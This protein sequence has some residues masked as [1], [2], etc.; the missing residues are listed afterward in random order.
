MSTALITNPNGGYRFLAGIDPYSSGAVAESG[1]EI[2]HVTLAELM[3]WREGLIAVRHYLETIGRTRHALCGVELRCPEPFSMDGFI[4]FNVGYRELLD[5]WNMMV[6]G[7]NPV[8]R[9]NVSPVTAPPAE[10][11][12]FGFSY[13][14]PSD[15]QHSTFVVAGGGEMRGQ[16]DAT[17]I[18][19]VGETS[20]DA[21]LEKARCVLDIMNK[22]WSRLGSSDLLTAINVYTAHPLH[23]LLK[24]V[25][26]PGLPPA[27][28]IGVRWHYTRPP[29]HDIEFEMDMRGV[30]RDLVIDLKAH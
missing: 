7:K 23:A 15:T 24:E 26:I 22:R 30:L 20:E 1:W 19:R 27:G 3:P 9:T 29:I 8:A 14:E 13:T 21:M 2:V 28:R 4:E 12:L 25:V 16:L 5:E 17:K 6:D 10:S 18:V 11:M